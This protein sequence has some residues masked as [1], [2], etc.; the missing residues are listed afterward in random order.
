MAMICAYNLHQIF[1]ENTFHHILYGP[2]SNM[3]LHFE[4]LPL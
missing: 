2:Q 4:Y 1:H 3:E